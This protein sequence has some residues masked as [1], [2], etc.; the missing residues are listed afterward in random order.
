M[1]L[2]TEMRPTKLA[3]VFGNEGIK[4]SLQ[5]ILSRS[6]LQPTPKAYLFAGRSG[7]GKTTFARLMASALGV[8]PD[9]IV[10]IN[11]AN[12]R[13]IDTIREAVIPFTDA[14]QR[15]IAGLIAFVLDECHRFTKDAQ[16]A[17]LKAVEDCPEHAFFFFCTTEPEGMIKT[18]RN[19][20]SIFQV[21]ALNMDDTLN[22]L[23]DAVEKYHFS[24][25]D[26]ILSK[27]ATASEGVPREALKL[28]EQIQ[29]ITDSK[30]IDSFLCLAG[31]DAQT[32]ELCRQLV[33][34][35]DAQS[36]WNTV[37]SIYAN[38][39]AEP[40]AIRRQILGYIKV[41][42][43]KTGNSIEADRFSRLM[44]LFLAADVWK[45]GEPALVWSLYVACGA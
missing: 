40:E 12:C 44:E 11:T 19:R 4:A 16:E 35:G 1:S 10:E 32:I 38:L 22:L 37:R 8:T 28:L 9:G 3:D 18:L 33:R 5:A 14:G 34:L 7:C 31:K 41:C 36:K 25:P 29:G 24:V 21:S 30:A 15:P 2:A 45:S 13:G 17:L 43:L 39:S 6:E 42:L 26:E 20:C 27:I 23:L